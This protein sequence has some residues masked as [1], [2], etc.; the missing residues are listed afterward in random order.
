M[1]EEELRDWISLLSVLFLTSFLVK[2]FFNQADNRE[3]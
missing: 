3:V 1:K 2:K